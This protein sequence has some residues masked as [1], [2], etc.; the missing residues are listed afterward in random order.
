MTR[1]PALALCL[2]LALTLG[3]APSASAAT[4]QLDG[5]TVALQPGT[6]QV[7]TVNRT[8]SWH[9]RVT[10]WRKTSAGWQAVLFQ[11]AK[12][13]EADLERLGITP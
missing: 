10:F 11:N 3:P 6:S 7:I 12:T 4:V 13:L 8:R 1:I 2:L 5:V 9:A